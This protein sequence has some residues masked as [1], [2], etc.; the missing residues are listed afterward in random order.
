MGFKY[1]DLAKATKDATVE[2]GDDEGSVLHITFRHSFITP[3]LAADIATLG[4]AEG[5]DME[6]LPSTERAAVV[7]AI[8]AASA[9][10]ANLVTWW[11]L[12]DD[13]GVMFPLDAD[14]IATKL[15]ID[16]QMRVLG[17]CLRESR[18]GE[19]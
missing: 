16:F 15:P 14:D 8:R 5:R 7:T 3:A 10:I 1:K 13:E 6:K 18:A 17:A 9:H 4:A 19:A 11:D 2:I 12:E